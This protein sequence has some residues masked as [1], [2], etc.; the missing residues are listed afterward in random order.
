MKVPRSCFWVH[1]CPGA[2]TRASRGRNELPT[3]QTPTPMLLPLA[4]DF[5]SQLPTGPKMMHLRSGFS[6]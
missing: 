2:N 5:A 4:L 1:P 6:K 3:N